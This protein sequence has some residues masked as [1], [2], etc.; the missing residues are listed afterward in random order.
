MV[1]KLRV[2]G[3]GEVTQ[4][5]AITYCF[6]HHYHH[7]KCVCVLGMV[8]AKCGIG[9]GVHVPF[10]HLTSYYLAVVDLLI[11]GEGGGVSVGCHY[12][13]CRRYAERIVKQ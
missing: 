13:Q 9:L 2:G 4:E 8:R 1:C 3:R 12:L 11:G 5:Y 10:A 7:C 6:L